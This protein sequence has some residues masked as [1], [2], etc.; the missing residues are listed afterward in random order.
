M[1]LLHD[2]GYLNDREY[3]SIQ[4]DCIEIEKIITSILK[5]AKANK[6]Q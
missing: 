1:S 5:T 2:S 6:E 3:R 4:T